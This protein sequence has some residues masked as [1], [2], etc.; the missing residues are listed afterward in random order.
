VET[1]PVYAELKALKAMPDGSHLLRVDPVSPDTEGAVNYDCMTYRW[2]DP[3]GYFCPLNVSR[4]VRSV[5]L[6]PRAPVKILGEPASLG[7]LMRYVK[8][9][10]NTMMRLTLDGVG[11]VIAIEVAM[12]GMEEDMAA[13][14][15][16]G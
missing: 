15:A 11:H 16:Q 13:M 5:T 14:D 2:V 4:K 12:S 10:K 8:Q 9:H 7:D 3:P 1:R 6:L